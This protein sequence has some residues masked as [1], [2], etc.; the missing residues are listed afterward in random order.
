MKRIA[1]FCDGTWNKRE[2]QIRTNIVRMWESLA[3][4]DG[5]NDQITIY[6]P[7]VG[8]TDHED[9]A[10]IG[11]A[12][13]NPA[14]LGKTEL[15]S[16]EEASLKFGGGAFGWGLD[17]KVLIAYKFLAQNYEAGDQVYV[18]GF[19]RGAY[20]ARSLLG[21]VRNCGLPRDCDDDT[22][23]L[24]MALYRSDHP[25]YAPNTDKMRKIRAWLSP[26]VSTDA[27]DQ[28]QR[29]ANSMCQPMNI[30]Y[31][32]VCD[33]VGALGVPA[34]LDN[35]AAFFNRK[36]RFHD[37]KLSGMIHSARQ[38]VSIDDRRVT[39]EPSLF[40]QG[41]LQELNDI[42]VAEE[43]PFQQMWF[44]G[45]HGCVGGGM[46]EDERGICNASLQWMVAGAEAQGLVFDQEKLAAY[47]DTEAIGPL[48]ST[49]HKPGFADK[50]TLK[51][52]PS[53]WR[54][55]I[56]AADATSDLVEARWKALPKYRPEP[57]AERAK[58]LGW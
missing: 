5:E 43:D 29:P 52:F 42:S 20:T 44:P 57:I 58:A 38:V 56:P 2:G 51:L 13:D 10:V 9:E 21:L 33:T 22:L 16:L 45:T 54:P 24:A 34:A 53:W 18:F 49:A 39:Y 55:E 41:K 1:I 37:T 35:L 12:G 40:D 6:I 48:T 47:A 14:K 32:G 7:G 19:S 28:A 46:P 30:A 26:R 25:D 3:R 31:L 15:N 17:R 50:L 8:L 4:S 11:H 36:Y 23:S 27:K